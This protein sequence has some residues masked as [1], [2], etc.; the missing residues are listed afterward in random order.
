MK[1]PSEVF[2]P[3]LRFTRE[4]EKMKGSPEIFSLHVGD[5][6]REAC[7]TVKNLQDAL[8][9]YA[10]VWREVEHLRARVTELEWSNEMACENTPT[11]NCSCPGCSLARDRAGEE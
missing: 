7:L 10:T 4:W 2:G 5:P 9:D 1:P 8:T 11:K 3:I 6:K